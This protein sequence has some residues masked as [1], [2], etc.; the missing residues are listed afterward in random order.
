MRFFSFAFLVP[1]TLRA[2]VILFVVCILGPYT[3]ATMNIEDNKRQIQ[4]YLP[5]NGL[6]SV[7]TFRCEED[8]IPSDS[9]FG[10]LVVITG[11]Y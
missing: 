7:I 2:S 3:N 10:A 5:W 8:S 11:V 6:A 4:R 9:R 1:W